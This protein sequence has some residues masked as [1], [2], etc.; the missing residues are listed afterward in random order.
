MPRSTLALTL[1][2]AAVL[3]ALTGAAFGLSQALKQQRTETMTVHQAVRRIVVRSDAG[4]VRLT[5]AAVPAVTVEQRKTWLW[6]APT[7]RATLRGGVL[8]LSG[9]CPGARLMDLCE[10]RFTLRVPD[11][12]PVRVEAGAGAIDVRGLQGDLDL[13]T[14]SGEIS[15]QDLLSGVVRAHTNS[16]ALRLGFI[17]APPVVLADSRS[18]DV[19]VALPVANYRVDASSRSG[20]VAVRGLLRDDFAPRHVVATS[21]SGTVAVHAR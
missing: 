14:S 21:S 20:D 8:V 1:V 9:R 2:V 13:R 11:G 18:G 16:G 15:A 12:V 4:S 7:V 5:P 6:E 19:D 17:S 10:T 3:L